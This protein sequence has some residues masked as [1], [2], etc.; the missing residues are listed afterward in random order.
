MADNKYLWRATVRGVSKPI[1]LVAQNFQSAQA[2]LSAPP[3]VAAHHVQRL[4]RID[5]WDSENNMT[6]VQ[7]PEAPTPGPPL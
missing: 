6:Q 5:L 4:S 2:Q 3:T 1:Y 7:W